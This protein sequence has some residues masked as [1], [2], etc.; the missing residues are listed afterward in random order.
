M[1]IV[2]FCFFIL[3]DSKATI[4]RKSAL[5]AIMTI[6]YSTSSLFHET[7]YYQENRDSVFFFFS[8]FVFPNYGDIIDRALH[9]FRVCNVMI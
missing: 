9:E 2:L 7:F 5:V 8:C 3:W 6:I 4:S 1:I